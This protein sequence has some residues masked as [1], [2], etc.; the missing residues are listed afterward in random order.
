MF[1]HYLIKIG[2]KCQR[3]TFLQYCWL[4]H[5]TFWTILIP[6]QAESSLF[7]T[8]R[9]DIFQTKG[10]IMDNLLKAACQR[11]KWVEVHVWLLPFYSKSQRCICK[12]PT[13][14]PLHAS[15]RN[16]YSSSVH[17]PSQF[18]Q[19]IPEL[20]KP[21]QIGCSVFDAELLRKSPASRESSALK[22]APLL[23]EIR[24]VD[25]KESLGSHCE[26]RRGIFEPL[27]LVCDKESLF[28]R[29]SQA[30]TLHCTFVLPEKSSLIPFIKPSSD[31]NE[32]ACHGR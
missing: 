13:T 30:Q 32:V 1:Q 22:D 24:H 25:W 26:A 19:N 9:G 5:A 7:S 6:V 28:Y 23:S 17:Q 31:L 27:N 29:I 10:H 12:C 21:S 3:T 4:L 20:Q 14:P 11:S 15:N 8:G 16:Y 18:D 2:L